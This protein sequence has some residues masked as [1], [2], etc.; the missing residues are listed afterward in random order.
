[1]SKYGDP[2]K[3]ALGE[4][5]IVNLAVKWCS[6]QLQAHF[7]S[8][9]GPAETTLPEPVLV[10]A[11]NFEAEFEQW[12]H[13]NGYSKVTA[14]IINPRGFTVENGLEGATAVAEPPVATSANV[15][16][17]PAVAIITVFGNCV[18]PRLLRAKLEDGRDVTF[19]IRR[20]CKYRRGQPVKCR[21]VSAEM[22][23]NP[24]YAPV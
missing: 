1:M 19:E 8:G 4:S 13:D 17:W 23:G 24:M 15:G 16:P 2:E 22:A 14:P 18:N 10:G 3:K 20:G 11:G 21:R 7:L 6:T 12:A 9:T 5:E